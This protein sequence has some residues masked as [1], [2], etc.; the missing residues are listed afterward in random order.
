MGQIQLTKIDENLNKY[1]QIIEYLKQDN[2]YWLKNDKWDFTKE[3]FYGR[4]I[5]NSR[6]LQFSS[7]RNMKSKMK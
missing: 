6:Y 5:R 2:E 1:D 3:I 4:R 7:F